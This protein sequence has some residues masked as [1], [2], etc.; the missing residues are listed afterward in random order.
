MDTAGNCRTSM[1]TARASAH[2]A[3]A[4]RP[5][6]VVRGVEDLGRDALVE[7]LTA[8]ELDELVDL[9]KGVVEQ[10]GIRPVDSPFGGD[11]M[12]SRGSVIILLVWQSGMS[13]SPAAM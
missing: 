12:S 2:V 9:L 10:L 1:D 8:E 13:M 4:E 7:R 6:G 11:S 3:H 5:P